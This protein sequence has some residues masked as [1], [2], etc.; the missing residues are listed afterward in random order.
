MF[1]VDVFLVVSVPSSASPKHSLVCG[2]TRVVIC[3]VANRSRRGLCVVF[4]PVSFA[5]CLCRDAQDEIPDDKM[6]K[7]SEGREFLINLIDSPGHVDF[8]A[9]V[10]FLLPCAAPRRVV[11]FSVRGR[12]TVADGSRRIAVSQSGVHSQGKTR[13]SPE[14]TA[15][16]V[17]ARSA[18]GCALVVGNGSVIVTG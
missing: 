12:C 7:D 9:E 13:P 1:V 10:S 16:H 14:P 18:V 2:I 15:L 17:A 3:F 11:H 8:S 6:P 5:S 4:V